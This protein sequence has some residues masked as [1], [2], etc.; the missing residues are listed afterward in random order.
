[1]LLVARRTGLMSDL[2]SRIR[3]LKRHLPYHES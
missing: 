2:A 3:L 1:M